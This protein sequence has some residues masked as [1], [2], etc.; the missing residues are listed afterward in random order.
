MQI[1]MIRQYLVHEELI[2]F[3][4]IARGLPSRWMQTS[5]RAHC[6]KLEKDWRSF[7]NEM[8]KLYR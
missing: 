6:A 2:Y 1:I 5:E 7:N 3:A 8:Q 4:Q